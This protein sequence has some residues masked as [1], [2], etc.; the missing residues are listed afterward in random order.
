MTDD[1]IEILGKSN[2]AICVQ[3][4][5]IRMFLRKGILTND[6]VATLSGEA[7]KAATLLGLSPDV[8]MI[9]DAA[10]RGFAQAWVKGVTTN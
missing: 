6:D 7:S 3:G 8:Q 2:A 1:E 4:A 10:I 9:T 5:L